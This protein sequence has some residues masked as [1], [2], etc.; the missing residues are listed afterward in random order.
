MTPY[1]KNE[2]KGWMVFFI[3]SGGD[4][5]LGTALNWIFYCACM[6]GKQLVDSRFLPA[7]VR[8]GP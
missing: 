7:D 2:E 5:G 1:C 8:T 6:E 4:L 3:S